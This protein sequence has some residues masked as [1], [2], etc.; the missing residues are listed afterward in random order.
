MR[1]IDIDGRTPMEYPGSRNEVLQ[2]ANT[3]SRRPHQKR[4][5]AEKS[6]VMQCAFSAVGWACI[7]NKYYLYSKQHMI[8][9][10]DLY[11]LL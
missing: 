5:N 11:C 2:D 3:S 8:R 1:V 10:E 7:R 4:G 9:Y 6:M